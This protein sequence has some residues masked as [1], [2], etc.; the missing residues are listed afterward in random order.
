ME[1]EA[2]DN[3][4]S[5]VGTTLKGKWRLDALLG[6][7][8]MAAVYSATHRNGKR[9]AIKMLHPELSMH[10]GI[11][12]RFQREGYVANKVAHPGA[13]QVDDD[14]VA[15]DGSAFIVMELLDGE[16]L[17][18]RAE[19]QGGRLE[20]AEVLGL[21]DRLL[22][23]LAAAHA[24]GI[25][26]RDLKPDNVFVT[27]AGDVKVLDFGIARVRE[28]STAQ[29]AAT[30][31]G[32]YMGTPAYMPPEQARGRWDLVDA[33][34]DLWAVGATMFALLSGREVHQ[35]GT[36]NELLVFACTQP[37]APLGT[38][39]PGIH[40]AVA[41]VVDRALAYEKEKRWPDARAMQAAVREA[42]SQLFAPAVAMAPPASRE[43]FPS[44][45]G[46]A[47]PAAQ[48]ALVYPSAGPVAQ[49]AVPAQPAGSPDASARV[50]AVAPTA[51]TTGAAASAGT[52]TGPQPRSYKTA[53]AVGAA[54]L[55]ALGMLIVLAVVVIR[56]LGPDENVV[57]H[58]PTETTPR[59]AASALAA[60][61]AV[62]APPVSPDR[63]TSDAG[64][65]PSVAPHAVA[66]A[67]GEPVKPAT[68]PAPAPRP[69]TV[70]R[71]P[72]PTTKRTAPAAPIDPM[73]MRR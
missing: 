72:T 61:P 5:R 67:K 30:R 26:H 44:W 34:T 32:S 4:R 12:T 6:V 51:L 52:W 66:G 62:P 14:D 2:L 60:A 13:L 37:A 56:A 42:Y 19:R 28:T 20:T 7:G 46:A 38:I 69:K 25:V 10:K 63:P 70:R 29:S 58:T 64:Q 55:G 18:A 68:T 31:T 53:V 9:V 16:T 57:A 3:A 8:G 40:P 59:A 27:R 47:P 73:D 21:T 17:R 54:G 43:P 35:A 36:L 49:T 50:A 11:R 24:A 48:G 45:P 15:D 41:A 23:V 33:Q 39:V 65:T 71:V 1:E 22:D